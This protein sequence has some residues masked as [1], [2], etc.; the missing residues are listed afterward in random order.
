MS[1]AW[2]IWNCCCSFCSFRCSVNC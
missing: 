1:V 2:Q